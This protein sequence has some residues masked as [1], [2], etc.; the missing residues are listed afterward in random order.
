MDLEWV[1]IAVGVSAAALMATMI[2]CYVG[3]TMVR[4]AFWVSDHWSR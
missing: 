1:G 4:F 3:E 2:I